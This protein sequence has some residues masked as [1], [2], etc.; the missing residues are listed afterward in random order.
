MS[1]VKQIV[2]TL[3]A[4]HNS[5][6][7]MSSGVGASRSPAGAHQGAHGMDLSQARLLREVM[8]MRIAPVTEQL[9][10]SF[11]AEKVLE[12]PRSY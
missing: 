8:I 6:E 9:I 5:K 4:F 10:M 11:I 7:A 3:S 1:G 2:N 12:L